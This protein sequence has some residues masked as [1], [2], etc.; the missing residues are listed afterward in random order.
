MRPVAFLV[1]VVAGIAF[2]AGVQ[3]LGTL[4]AGAVLGTWAWTVSGLSAP[5]LVLPFL[6]G[7]TQSNVR[8][9]MALGLVVSLAA[10]LGYFAMTYSPVEGT[11]LREFLPGMLTMMRSGY[12]P[13]WIAGGVVAGPL[14]GLLGQRWR[15]TRWWV[16]AA[17]VACALCLEPLARSASGTLSPHPMVWATEVAVGI[18]VGAAFVV[19]M[20]AARRAP[21]TNAAPTR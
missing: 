17:L 21:A 4:T 10:L 3:Y 14:Y 8:R 1:A 2:G 13:L 6:A 11:P 15:V 5:W 20:V 19:G 16:S 9:A 12:N 18:V 7:M